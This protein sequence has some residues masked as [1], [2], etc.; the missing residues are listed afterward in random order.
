ML[1]RFAS[2]R[3]PNLPTDLARRRHRRRS[4][5]S[6]PD[7]FR[8]RNRGPAM[9]FGDGTREL[10]G[11]AVG[12]VLVVD[13]RNNVQRVIDCCSKSA[14]AGVRRM[15][16]LAEARALMASNPS[17]GF[18]P[19]STLQSP[20]TPRRDR[21]DLRRLTIACLRFAPVA[22]VDGEA[23]ILLDLSGCR[24]LL[25]RK[26]GEVGLLDRME[27]CFTRHGFTFSMAIADTAVAARA[28][29]GYRNAWRPFGTDHHAPERRPRHGRPG[30]A[31]DAPAPP[32][33]RIVPSGEHASRLEGLPVEAIGLDS[34]T[35]EALRAVNVRL[36]G[37]LRRLPRAALPARYGS[38]V[39]HRLDQAT[40][41]IP[42]IIDPVRPPNAV[43]VRR[44]F[45]GPVRSREAIELAVADLLKDLRH[46]LETLESGACVVRLKA[47]RPMTGD[48]VEVVEPRRPTRRR[49]RLWTMLQP[50]IERLPLDDGVDAIELEVPR[51]RRIAHESSPMIHSPGSR[52]GGAG[53]APVEIE[54]TEFIEAV[55]ARFGPNTVRRMSASSGHVPEDES[56]IVSVD[57]ATSEA[58]GEKADGTAAALGDEAR[59]TI[60]HRPPI[61]IEVR[62][63]RGIP[64]S[65]FHEGS[66]HAVGFGLMVHSRAHPRV[67]ARAQLVTVT[68]WLPCSPC[69]LHGHLLS[70]QLPCRVCYEFS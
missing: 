58:D 20:S 44:E 60:I 49:G 3:L 65:V 33:H 15:M 53:I 23:G 4:G 31:I 8:N 35:L 54:V 12:H 34:G 9:K 43:A 24:R 42:T 6:S 50:V 37:E 5:R 27:R 59:P 36:V 56:R 19:E 32:D 64:A 18:R 46:R 57:G 47:E 29:A 38:A 28:W 67:H 13:L 16:T 22:V 17:S 41:R 26:G 55:Q 39:L 63:D 68:R 45:D 61:S 7:S 51:H 52:E 14:Q 30:E 11:D 21:T 48:W 69:C 40:G 62:C 2:I 10:Q 1:R 25:R 70:L 66:P